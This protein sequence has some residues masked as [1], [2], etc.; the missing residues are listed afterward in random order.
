MVLLGISFKEKIEMENNRKNNDLENRNE[1]LTKINFE[2][3]L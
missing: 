3:S 1:K 2:N